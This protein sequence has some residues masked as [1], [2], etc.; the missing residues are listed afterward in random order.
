M[1]CRLLQK[2]YCFANISFVFHVF[3]YLDPFKGITENMLIFSGPLNPVRTRAPKSSF[4][5]TDDS[6]LTGKTDDGSLVVRE[7]HDCVKLLGSQ[8]V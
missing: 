2:L 5:L 3:V 6:R 1:K 7:I 8:R 4:F